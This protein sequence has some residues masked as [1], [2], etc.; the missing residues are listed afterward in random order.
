MKKTKKVSIGI[1]EHIQYICAVWLTLEEVNEHRFRV[2]SLYRHGTKPDNLTET[3]RL[4][5][6]AHSDC[7]WLLFTHKVQT[8]PFFQSI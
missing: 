7:N 1:N 4:Q 2:W 6:F 3:I 5:E 8:S